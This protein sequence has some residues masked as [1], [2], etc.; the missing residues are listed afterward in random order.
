MDD[1]A[2]WR[3]RIDVIDEKLLELLNER[4]TCA[5]E[6]GKLKVKKNREIYDPVR[7]KEIISNIREVNKGPLSNDIAQKL[8]EN[9]IRELRQLEKE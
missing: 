6:I 7:E 8:F 5:I 2:N 1:I 4:A 9:L 3:K